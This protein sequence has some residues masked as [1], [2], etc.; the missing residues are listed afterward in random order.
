MEYASQ[1]EGLLSSYCRMKHFSSKIT[2]TTLNIIKCL[3][4][5]SIF[6]VHITRHG[7]SNALL[8]FYMDVDGCVFSAGHASQAESDPVA[9]VLDAWCNLACY[10]CRRV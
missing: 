3:D 7:K 1:A 8:H 9:P 2:L 6:T 4:H 5:P 10:T